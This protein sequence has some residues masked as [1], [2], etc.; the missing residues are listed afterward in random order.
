MIGLA[1]VGGAVFILIPLARD[2]Y[3][4]PFI[5]AAQFVFG[6]CALAVN[7]NG[8]SLVQTITP[9]RMLGRANA[10][11]RFVVWGVMPFGG[12]LGGA[13]AS[14]SGYV[15]PLLGRRDGCALAF[16]PLLWSPLRHLRVEDATRA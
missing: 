8:I 1:A 4:I 10:S 14:A 11:R 5:V 16:L 13:L 3:A 6:Y 12:L 9:D 2:G 15:P 7:V